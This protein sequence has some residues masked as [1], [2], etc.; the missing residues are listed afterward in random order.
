MRSPC[1]RWASE[2]R[3]LSYSSRVYPLVE[4]LYVERLFANDFRMICTT[5]PLPHRIFERT[6]FRWQSSF[7]VPFLHLCIFSAAFSCHPNELITRRMVWK[8]WCAISFFKTLSTEKFQWKVFTLSTWKFQV[9]LWSQRLRGERVAL[10]CA[11]ITKHCLVLP[12]MP[13]RIASIAPVGLRIRLASSNIRSVS[14]EHLPI[15][16]FALVLS[17]RSGAGIKSLGPSKTLKV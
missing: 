1:R 10:L 13:I 4:G 3:N 14:I 15:W 7:S 6:K 11:N 2:L 17:F 9:R 16:K 5:S 8:W 12:A